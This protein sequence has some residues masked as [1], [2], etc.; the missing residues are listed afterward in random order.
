MDMVDFTVSQNN[1]VLSQVLAVKKNGKLTLQSG[2]M[3]LTA[4]VDE[5]RR[6]G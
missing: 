3:K 6:L 2:P 1:I 4:N 5:V